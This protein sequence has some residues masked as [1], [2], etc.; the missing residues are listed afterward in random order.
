MAGTTEKAVANLQMTVLARGQVLKAS[1]ALLKHINSEA[2]TTTQSGKQNLLADAD[3]PAAE[4]PI[5]LTV[6]TKKHIN[7]TNRFV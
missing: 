7:D 5:W 6:T 3:T 1:T 2:A 4:T